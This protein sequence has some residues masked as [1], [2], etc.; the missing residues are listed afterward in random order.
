[1]TPTST[2]QVQVRVKDKGQKQ[3][4]DK[5]QIIEPQI[6]IVIHADE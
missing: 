5:D 3:I 4:N 2:D 6:A 1:M